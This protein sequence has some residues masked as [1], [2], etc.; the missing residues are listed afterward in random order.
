MKKALHKLAY[1]VHGVVVGMAVMVLATPAP[2]HAAA[3]SFTKGGDLSDLFL[4]PAC[5]IN[6]YLIPIAIALEVVLFIFGIIR[7]IADADNQEQRQQ[8]SQFIMWGVIALF[9]TLSFWAVVGI[10]QRTLQLG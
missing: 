8:G 4:F 7:Y 9:I 2:S 6:E 5:L 1:S 3:C 10:L